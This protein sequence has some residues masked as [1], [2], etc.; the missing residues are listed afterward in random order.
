M[1]LYSS[2]VYIGVLCFSLFKTTWHTPFPGDVKSGAAE[3]CSAHLHRHHNE[4]LVLWLSCPYLAYLKRI[5]WF[6]MVEYDKRRGCTPSVLEAST[7]CVRR[8]V[9][10]GE[11]CI[12]TSAVFIQFHYAPRT[13]HC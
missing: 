12:I 9:R 7:L 6:L 13:T 8:F 10:N 1:L 4:S 11:V 3:C 2:C 5:G